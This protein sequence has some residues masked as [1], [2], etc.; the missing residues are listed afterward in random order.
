MKYGF[1]FT[2][3]SLS[4]LSVCFAAPVDFSGTYKCQGFDPYTNQPY[5]GRIVISQQNTVYHLKMK[6]DTDEAN[7]T[8]GLYDNQTIS[9]VFQDI[10]DPKKIGLERYSYSKDH[11]RIEGYWVYLGQDKLGKEA[12]EKQP[13]D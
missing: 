5:K 3:L 11:K 9:V 8:G 1:L 7:G 12:C 10:N 13:I 4:F 2:L 6:Y